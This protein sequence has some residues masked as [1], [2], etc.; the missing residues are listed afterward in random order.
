M[1]IERALEKLK[2]ANAADAAK[3]E[4]SSERRVVE[5]QHVDRQPAN[6]LERSVTEPLPERRGTRAPAAA[7]TI[8]A[9]A[10][11]PE[12]I[13]R[14]QFPQLQS[15]RDLAA[16]H[17]ILLP[18]TPLAADGR[19]GA[20]YR[21]I[22]TRLYN[23]LQTNSWTSLAVTS[24]EA[25]E[26]KSVTSINLALSFARDASR[27]VFLIDLD[28]RNPTVCRY[29]GVQPPQSVVDYFLGK[30]EAKDLFFSIGTENLVVAGNL[31]STELA[32]E[33]LA[34]DRLERLFAY[35]KS[36]SP[37]PLIILDLPPTL[38]TDEALMLAPRVDATVLVV[39][40]GET[41]RDSLIRARTLLGE[42]SFA[43]VILNK[44]SEAPGK[45]GYYYGYGASDK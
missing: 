43:G 18:G 30:A 36:I 25:G 14:P 26:G 38:V 22:R 34:G 40:D 28:M 19:I 44:S 39:A 24:P 16:Q 45:S 13:V 35:I 10:A 1:V 27:S 23:L 7:P 29:L 33:L 2:Q 21:I 41:R 32:S 42:F 3:R 8:A 9:P 20:A 5:A 4:R 37:N 15:S 11:A 12:P 31:V 6:Y 17:R